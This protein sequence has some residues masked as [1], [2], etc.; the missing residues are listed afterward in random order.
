[1]KD[2]NGKE[3]SFDD[4]YYL[5]YL[6]AHSKKATRLWHMAGNF[7]TIGWVSLCLVFGSYVSWCLA[8]LVFTPFIVYPFAWG[9]H[10]YIEKNKPLAWSSPLWAKACDWRM[11]WDMLNGRF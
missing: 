8:G 11:C 10:L 2:E 3:I 7:A 1:M 5:T 9:S 4:Y 6:P